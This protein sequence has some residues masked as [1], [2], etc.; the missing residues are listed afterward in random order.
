MTDP[1]ARDADG[2]AGYVAIWH[3]YL[4]D[5]CR[6][7]ADD[8]SE[9]VDELGSTSAGVVLHEEPWYHVLNLIT[10]SGNAPH[11]F[12]NAPNDFLGWEWFNYRCLHRAIYRDVKFDDWTAED[13]Q[14]TQ[15]RARAV[16]E[17]E[18]HGLRLRDYAAQ[19][20]A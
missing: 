5:W 11:P 2:F 3:R 14:W 10:D 7:S 13:E 15:A 4:V 1:L 16:A 9:F 12:P 20:M 17:L 6:M 19:D 18:K 8:F